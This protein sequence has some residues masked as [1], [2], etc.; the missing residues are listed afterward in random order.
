M[1]MD[2]A[3]ESV[4]VQPQGSKSSETYES[5][6]RIV[7]HGGNS[8]E[9]PIQFHFADGT[10]LDKTWDG[11]EG[12]IEFKLTHASPVDWVRIDPKYTL[13]LENKHINNFYQT[14]VDTKWKIRWN[15]G[16]VQ[17]LQAIFGFVA[18]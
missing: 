11:K 6:V 7:K 15:L 17:L 14:Q 13:I 16:I 12:S 9:V 2:Y 1:M 10:T 5:T 4:N 3:V 8:S 18:W